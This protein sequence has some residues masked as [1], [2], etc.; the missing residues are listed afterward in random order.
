LETSLKGPEDFTSTG[1]WKKNSADSEKNVPVSTPGFFIL[2]NAI[3]RLEAKKQDSL[4]EQCAYMQFLQV[5]HREKKDWDSRKKV[6]AISMC[7]YGGGGGEVEASK[8]RFFCTQYS[9]SSTR[10]S[11]SMV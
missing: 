8:N 9:F 7:V 10:Y 3:F 4:W 5:S 1:D 2:G 11:F 6:A